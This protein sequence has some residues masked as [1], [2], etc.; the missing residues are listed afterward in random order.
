MN[1]RFVA[2]AAIGAAVLVSLG[3]LA[4]ML[5]TGDSK[6]GT[7]VPAVSSG[8]IHGASFSDIQGNQ[9]ALSK[10]AG[11]LL[12]L[13]FWA[14]WC[15]P[16]IEEMPRLDELHKKS[17]NGIQV[18]GIAADNPANVVKFSNRLK[19]SYPILIDETGAMAFSKRLG[20]R[21]ALLPFSVLVS[22]QGDIVATYVGTLTPEKIAQF[23]SISR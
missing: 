16:C 5:T 12:L 17:P 10:W 15:S 20:N 23:S 2:A 1:R 21:H 18:V 14:T 3:I 4:T 8:V 19:V 11:K 22:P 6:I 9:Q 7:A 13:N